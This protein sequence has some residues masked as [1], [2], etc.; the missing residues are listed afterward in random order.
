MAPEECR[1]QDVCLTDPA[2]QLARVLVLV[3]GPWTEPL[4][5][6]AGVGRNCVVVGHM[7]QLQGYEKSHTSHASDVW[8][9]FPA[10]QE[11][12]ESGGYRG[13]GWMGPQGSCTSC[14]DPRKDRDRQGVD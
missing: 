5:V 4:R 10:R 13:S 7:Q 1:C 9:F 6:G 8:G 2:L 14:L 3:R 11:W 12:M